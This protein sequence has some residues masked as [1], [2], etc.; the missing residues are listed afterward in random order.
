MSKHI[1]VT[2]DGV[3]FEG[4]GTHG[5]PFRLY[6]FESPQPYTVEI[7]DTKENN[8]VLTFED[9]TTEKVLYYR[10]RDYY[11]LTVTNPAVGRMKLL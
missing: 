10:L 9:A 5:S 7:Y 3:Q 8:R 4:K 2:K 1:K 11:T 6:L